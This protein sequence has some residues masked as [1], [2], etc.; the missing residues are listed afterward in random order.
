MA[1]FAL[2]HEIAH[3]LQRH[4]TRSIQARITDSIGSFEGL[5]KLIDGA[6][7]NPASWLAYSN[8]LMT[9]FERTLTE[10]STARK[11]LNRLSAIGKI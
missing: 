3:L 5:C 11:Q 9:R 4:E 6:T 1:Y 10:V 7:S 8:E 2:A